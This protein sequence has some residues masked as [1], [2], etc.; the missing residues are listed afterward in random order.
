MHYEVDDV[1]RSLVYAPLPPDHG[2]WCADPVF[3]GIGWAVC[4]KGNPHPASFAWIPELE[5]VSG[6]AADDLRAD[7]LQPAQAPITRTVDR[8]G[9]VFGFMA[10][11][12]A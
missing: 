9:D 11:V 5:P 6:V 12:H 3:T 1:A 10:V 7:S 4:T 8:R 2:G